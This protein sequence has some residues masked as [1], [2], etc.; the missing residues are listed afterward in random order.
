MALVA[1]RPKGLQKTTPDFEG[2]GGVVLCSL[3]E[4]LALESGTDFE[5]GDLVLTQK[6]RKR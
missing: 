3:Q 4:H 2:E 6:R 5:F 1:H